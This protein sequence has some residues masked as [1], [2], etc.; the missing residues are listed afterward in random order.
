MVVLLNFMFVSTVGKVVRAG[1]SVD[2]WDDST[3][4]FRHQKP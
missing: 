1:I 3:I 4:E 2:T